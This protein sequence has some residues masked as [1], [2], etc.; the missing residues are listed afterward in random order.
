ME[1]D[2]KVGVFLCQCDGQISNILSLDRIE[3][4]VSK[5]P[6]VSLVSNTNFPCSKTGLRAIQSAIGEKDLNRIVVAGCSPRMV[7]QLF[8]RTITEAGLNSNSLEIANV[9]DFCARVHQKEKSAAT[10]K[11][12]DMIKGAID[13]VSIKQPLENLTRE[14]VKNVA[15]IG[16]GIAGISAALSLASR[17]NK[18]T[19]I[20]KDVQLGGMLNSVYRLYPR[21]TDAAE[22]IKEKIEQIKTTKNIEVQTGAEVKDIHGSVGQYQ[23]KI[24]SKSN[25]KKIE[26]GAVVFATG[27]EYFYP[28]GLYGYGSD[29]NI[30]TQLEFETMLRQNKLAAKE[31]VFIQCVGS[32]NEERPYCSRFCC[33]ATFKNVL[34]LKRANPELKITVI[35]RGLTEYIREYDEAVDLGV[36]FIRYD[37]ENPPQVKNDFIFVTDEKTDKNFEI[38]F[39]LLV[40]ATPMIPGS[41]SKQWGKKLRLPVDEYGFIL[42]P[43]VKLRP[44]RFAPD[45]I[46]VAGTVHWPG[47]VSD[48]IGQGVS[49]AARAF[50][51]IQK[52]T[53]EREPIIA[54][55]DPQ[56]CRG[57]ERCVEVCLFQAIKMV[58]D[59]GGFQHAKIDEFVCK[60]CGM[61]A[62]V[63]IC[64]AAQVKHLT[65]E[66]VNSM[67]S[68]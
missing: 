44:K 57:C 9:R 68:V 64:G 42:E 41:K 33:P 19:L 59:D 36:L 2:I 15:V 17:G 27:S 63:C 4:A 6:K 48:S 5:N 30:I 53:I 56:I 26:A 47:L 45:G 49:A 35:F 29:K 32:R 25:S 7:E 21:E 39:E 18:V 60:G 67:V 43:H 66:Q 28:N 23:I 13:T 22:F 1:K 58:K 50:S 34:L 3:K 31:M 54:E 52:E 51:L 38:P 16:G 37:P 14:V 65:D 40:L 12:I 10:T 11:A 8:V 55:I 62:T 61:C 24:N 20:E 46:F